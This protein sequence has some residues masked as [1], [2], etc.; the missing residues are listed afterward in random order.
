MQINCQDLFYTYPKASQ[1]IFS[2]L[3]WSL[4]GPGFFSVFGFSGV[5]KSTLARLITGE[6]HPDSGHI[7]FRGQKALYA[8][9]AERLPGWGSIGEHLDSVTSSDKKGL[10]AELIREYRIEKCLD[11]AFSGLSMGQ[12]NRVNLVRYLVQDFD[13]L[14]CDEVLANVDE[15]TRNRILLDVKRLFPNKTFIYISHNALEVARFSRAVLILPQTPGGIVT[16]TFLIEG[17]DQDGQLIPPPQLLQEKV[18]EILRAA[19]SV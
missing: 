3:T 12:R 17:L 9:N 4:E 14:I 18:F 19:G 6:L 2:R 13:L 1:P 11:K 15:P 8:H 10:L 7:F 5:G 16:R